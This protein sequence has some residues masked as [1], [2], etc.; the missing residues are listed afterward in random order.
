[1]RGGSDR[2]YRSALECGRAA[3]AAVSKQLYYVM[4]TRIALR[5]RHYKLRDAN[6]LAPA[7]PPTQRHNKSYFITITLTTMILISYLIFDSDS[8]PA[9]EF[10]SGLRS[11]F[12]FCS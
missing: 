10:V 12:Q 7:A 5:V 11:R 9:F 4:R 3:P 2:E 8:S 1:M 6:K